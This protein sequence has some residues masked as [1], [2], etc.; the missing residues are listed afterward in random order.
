M[1]GASSEQNGGSTSGGIMKIKMLNN[2]VLVAPLAKEPEPGSLIVKPDTARPDRCIEEGV[3]V[4]VGPGKLK[5]DGTIV[6]I[7]VHEGDKVFFD[8]TVYTEL[9][10]SG[11]VYYV[12]E[13]DNIMG[14]VE[15]KE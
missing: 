5:P 15:P 12:L 13:A 7:Q 1:T 4:S 3:V 10:L 9:K 11:S 2:R 6:S 14:I 8:H